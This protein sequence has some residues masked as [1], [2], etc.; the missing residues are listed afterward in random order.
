MSMQDRFNRRINSLGDTAPPLFGQLTL[1][2]LI[3]VSIYIVGDTHLS[4]QSY[5]KGT[6]VSLLGYVVP[7]KIFDLPYALSLFKGVF[8][9]VSRCLE[10]PSFSWSNPNLDSSASHN[11]SSMGMRPKLYDTR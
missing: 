2:V 6:T 11:N 7:E 4:F 10:C 3:A 5:P 9:C 8:F 1:W